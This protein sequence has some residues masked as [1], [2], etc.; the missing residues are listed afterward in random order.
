[1]LAQFDD[2]VTGSFGRLAGISLTAQ[3]RQ[4][5]TLPVKLGCFGLVSVV[6]AVTVGF[7]A[8]EYK[9][10]QVLGRRLDLRDNVLAAP[11]EVLRVHSPT[12]ATTP[13]VV[14]V[15]AQRVPL[16]DLAAHITEQRWW[17]AA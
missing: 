14:D 4:Q 9:F 3:A 8:A 5:L 7:F 12:N 17:T 10:V 15:I 6:E 13:T 1:M 2:I 11:S 16:S